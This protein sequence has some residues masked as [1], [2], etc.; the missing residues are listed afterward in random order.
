[1][2]TAST[3]PATVSALVEE[4]VAMVSAAAWMPTRIASV[5]HWIADARAG[6][7]VV[8]HAVATEFVKAKT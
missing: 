6:Q 7:A 5:A 8:G 4:A 1:V 2:K 3:A